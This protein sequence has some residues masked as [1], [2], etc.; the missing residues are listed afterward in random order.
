MKERDPAAVSNQT[1]TFNER[2]LKEEID[3]LKNQISRLKEE[4]DKDILRDRLA[5][6]EKYPQSLGIQTFSE[7]L[8]LTPAIIGTLQISDDE[9]AALQKA[10][11]SAKARIDA[12][13]AKH[14]KIVENTPEKAV[15]DIAAYQE[16]TA[17]REEL[18]QSIRQE[19]GGQRAAVFI[20][21]SKWGIQAEFSDFGEQQ[22]LVEITWQKDG[23]AIIKETYKGPNNSGVSSKT[24]P[25]GSKLPER[26]QKI[27]SISSTQQ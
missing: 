8:A 9:C 7:S 27:L 11:H 13:E 15:I 24:Q 20:D 19:L 18:F 16:G 3:G 2:L 25:M 1:G 23:E 12:C 21:K 26:Y 4:K 17:V 10:L 6:L 22:T 5:L 14:L